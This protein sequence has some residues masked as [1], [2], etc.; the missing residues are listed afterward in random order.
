MGRKKDVCERERM[1]RI[2]NGKGSEGKKGFE[3]K[4]MAGGGERAGKGK[5]MDLGTKR[6]CRAE[7]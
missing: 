7:K 3:K 1:M 2:K 4:E 5:E 6:L